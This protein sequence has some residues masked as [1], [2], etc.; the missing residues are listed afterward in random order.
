MRAKEFIVER[1][2]KDRKAKPLSTTYEFPSM[3]GDSVYKIYRFSMMMGNADIEYAE[4]PAA[5]NAVVMAYTPEEE[6]KVRNAER[7]TGDKGRLLTNKGS[8]EPKSISTASPVAKPK[9]N[10]YGV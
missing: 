10:K 2:F 1:K 9:R 3:P 4:G 6:E 8:T 5:A 7:R